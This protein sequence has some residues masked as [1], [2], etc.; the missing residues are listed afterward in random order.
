MRLLTTILLFIISP[1][2]VLASSSNTQV[3]T[4]LVGDFRTDYYTFTA[5]TQYRFLQ[6]G[7]QLKSLWRGT[8]KTGYFHFG[9][10]YF[11]NIAA[12]N[13]IRPFGGVELRSTKFQ[14]RLYFEERFINNN[15]AISRLRYRFQYNV[16]DFFSIYQETFHEINRDAFS[17]FRLGVDLSYDFNYFKIF[18]RPSLFML[19]GNRP[20]NIY[21]LGLYKEF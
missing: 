10:A 14:N 18:L 17:E 7:D 1:R 2:W 15:I 6:N 9:L 16:L 3:W 5:E 19:K 11:D 20:Q 12:N 13:E 8:Y 21:Q 4:S